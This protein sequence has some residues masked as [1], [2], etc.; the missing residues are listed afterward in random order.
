MF[1]QIKEITAKAA[2]ALDLVIEFSTLGEYGLEYPETMARRAEP[3]AP[4]RPGRRQIKPVTKTTPPARTRTVTKGR[5]ERRRRSTCASQ[6]A[7]SLPEALLPPRIRLD[8]TA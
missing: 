2:D 6:T 8:L 4:C 5:P 1:V 3:S 7:T